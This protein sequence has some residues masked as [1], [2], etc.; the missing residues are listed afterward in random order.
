MLPHARH[1]ANKFAFYSHLIV[2]FAFSDEL[3]LWCTVQA[4]VIQKKQPAP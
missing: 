1:N 2:I 3:P 4:E